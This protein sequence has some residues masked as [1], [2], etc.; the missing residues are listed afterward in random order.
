MLLVVLIAFQSIYHVYGNETINKS[1]GL[2]HKGTIKTIEGDNGDIIDC[3][4]IYQQPAFDHPLINDLQM[5]PNT[6]PIG[7]KMNSTFEFDIRQ[8]WNKNEECPEE[9]IPIRRNTN[10]SYYNDYH[11]Q[12]FSMMGDQQNQNIL[13][14]SSGGHEYAMAFDEGSSYYGTQAVFNVWNPHVERNEFSSSQVW[15]TSSSPSINTIEAG[16][17]VYPSKFGDTHT[18]FFIYWTADNYQRTG[19]FDLD[20]PGFVQTNRHYAIG[21]TISPFSTYGG[22]SQE[23]SVNIFKDIPSGNWWLQ[24]SGYMVGYWPKS[25]FTGLADH[26]TDVKWGGEILNSRTRGQHT[27]T[28]MGSGHFFGEGYRKS[29]FIRQLKVA[30]AGLFPRE[31]GYLSK[32]VTTP[33][34][35]NLNFWKNPRTM[36]GTHVYFGGPGFSSICK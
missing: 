10:T 5:E 7:T 16:W 8:D 12:T 3:V 29:S 31:P 22:N 15:I 30:D 33:S 18:H 9:T 26:A 21:T 25:I 27:T 11:K 28:Q 17:I 4:D 36:M 6:Y 20:C 14:R 19:C 35:Y 1:L 23:I 24:V 34:C 32:I 2:E 13:Q